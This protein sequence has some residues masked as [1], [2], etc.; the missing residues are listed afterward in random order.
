MRFKLGA[1]SGLL[2]DARGAFTNDVNNAAKLQKDARLIAQG[3]DAVTIKNEYEKLQSNN[4]RIL[5]EVYKDVEALRTLNFTEAEIRDL[6]SGRR[7][8]SKADVAM[9]MNGFYNPEKMPSF[10]KDSALQNTIKNINK[11]LGTN[12]KVDDFVNT[13]ELKEIFKSYQKI[14]LGLSEEAREEFLRSTPDRKG[15]LL[16]L[17]K[18]KRSLLRELQQGP[19]INDPGGLG[20]IKQPQAQLPASNFLPDPQ[21]ANMFAANINPTTGLTRTEEALLSPTE[22]VIKQRLRT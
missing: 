12:F 20:V 3:L 5:S 8:L 21:I 4:Y 2:S 22:Q 15:D 1:Y 9:V 14:P 19:L 17:E 6:L 11:E 18:E 13:Q 16:D 10:R 7:A